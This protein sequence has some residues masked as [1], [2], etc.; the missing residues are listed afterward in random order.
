MRPWAAEFLE[1]AAKC[2]EIVVFTAAE[3][4][5]ADKVIDLLDPERKLVKHRLY[6]DSCT[7]F[8]SLFVKD[9]NVLGRDLAK[10]VIV[11]NSPS[12]FAFNVW[13]AL[14][15]GRERDSDK[16]V[17]GR[18]GGQGLEDSTGSAENALRKQGR[19]VVVGSLLQGRAGVLVSIRP[20]FE[21]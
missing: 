8:N 5:Y 2:F 15:V 18:R 12:A 1:E 3:Q 14:T 20:S 4:N 19:K 6:R 17:L 9:L 10:T 13:A 11:D 7:E 21:F 16:V